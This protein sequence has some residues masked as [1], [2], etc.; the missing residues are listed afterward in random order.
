MHQPM[1]SEGGCR[2]FGV[3]DVRDFVLNAPIEGIH[4][5]IGYDTI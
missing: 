2:C 3:F 4:P 5:C 1:R